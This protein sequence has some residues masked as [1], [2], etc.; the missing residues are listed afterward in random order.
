MLIMGGMSG[1]ST[2]PKKPHHKTPKR[3]STSI[4]FDPTN[5]VDYL[6]YD[7]RFA[8][9]DCTH[10]DFANEKCTLGYNSKWHRKEFQKKSY[11]LSGK[12]ALC[13]FLEID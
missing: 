6:K 1:K 9:E 2:L 13:R 8:C 3:L 5:P 11:E 7:V 10:F 4:R 12:M